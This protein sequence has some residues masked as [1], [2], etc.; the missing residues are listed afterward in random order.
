MKSLPATKLD[1]KRDKPTVDNQLKTA[2]MAVANPPKE[3]EDIPLMTV[4]K[5]ASSNTTDLETRIREPPTRQ[6]SRQS[7][8]ISSSS[9]LGTWLRDL[10]PCSLNSSFFELAAHVKGGIL[11]PV[12]SC[13]MP[14]VKEEETGEPVSPEVLD[15][16][17]GPPLAEE[18][19]IQENAYQPKSNAD[20]DKNDLPVSFDDNSNPHTTLDVLHR[21]RDSCSSARSPPSSLTAISA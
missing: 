20:L 19:S 3:T 17:P 13:T 7:T 14:Q 5:A 2:E 16:L 12:Q 10:K 21:I 11:F 15:R 8:P 1:E 6:P 4:I 9:Q 18:V